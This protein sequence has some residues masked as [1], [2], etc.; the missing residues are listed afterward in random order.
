MQVIAPELVAVWLGLDVA[1]DVY[2]GIGTALF[3]LAMF[4]HPRFGAA[5]AVPGLIIAVI[6]VALNLAIFPTPPA[7]ANLF[8]AGPLV[9]LWYLAVSIQVWRSLG[10]AQAAFGARDGAPCP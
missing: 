1:W 10:W 8:D 2:M 9:G 5:F 6:L 3:A 7:D 4:R